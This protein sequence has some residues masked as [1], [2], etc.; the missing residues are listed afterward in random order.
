MKKE[1]YTTDQLLNIIGSYL[2]M[3]KRNG[4]PCPAVVLDDIE[5]STIH[6]LKQ[7]DYNGRYKK[8]MEV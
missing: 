1:Q 6:V 2:C 4:G 7:N 3:I 5:K 8:Y